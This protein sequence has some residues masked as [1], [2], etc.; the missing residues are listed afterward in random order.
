[1]LTNNI[2]RMSYIEENLRKRHGRGADD[3]EKKEEPWDPQAE[4]YRIDP[5]FPS[6]AKPAA[7][8]WEE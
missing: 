4:L 2:L 3:D 6:V 1:M 7:R 5:T 8:H